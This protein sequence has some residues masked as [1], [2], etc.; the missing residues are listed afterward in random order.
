MTE[1]GKTLRTKTWSL[2]SLLNHL[3]LNCII[4]QIFHFLIF[5]LLIAFPCTLNVYVHTYILSYLL[6]V[7]KVYTLDL[8][9][10]I[11]YLSYICVYIYLHIYGISSTIVLYSLSYMC[12]CFVNKMCKL[13]NSNCTKSNNHASAMVSLSYCFGRKKKPCKL[14]VCNDNCRLHLEFMYGWHLHVDFFAARMVKFQSTSFLLS[15]AEWDIKI[16]AR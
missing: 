11:Y 16:R 7:I 10:H 4:Y 1:V 9:I 2:P 6:Y 3:K 12:V 15:S 8:C 13:K 14:S 5:S